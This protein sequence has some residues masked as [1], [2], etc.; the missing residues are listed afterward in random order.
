MHDNTL[1]TYKS[2]MAAGLT[3]VWENTNI[4]CS[5]SDIIVMLESIDRFCESSNPV[6]HFL[7]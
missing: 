4:Y 3:P 1:L 2:R 5:D 6:T 7:F